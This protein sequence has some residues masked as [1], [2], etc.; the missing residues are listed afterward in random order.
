MLAFTTREDN[1][2]DKAI[3]PNGPGALTGAAGLP[4]PPD[5]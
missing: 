4:R 1:E 3:A 5:E 2:V